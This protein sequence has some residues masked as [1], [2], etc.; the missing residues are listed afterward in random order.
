LGAVDADLQYL[1]E[2]LFLVKLRI[3]EVVER[4]ID[5]LKES[6]K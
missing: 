1:M 6:G 2:K 5:G 3:G 4:T